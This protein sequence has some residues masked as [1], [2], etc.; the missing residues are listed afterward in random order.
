MSFYFN[1]FF[2]YSQVERLCDRLQSATRIE[3]RRDA[4]RALRALSKVNKST[5]FQ[6]LISI[7]NK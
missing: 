5:F 2:V 3:D 6:C 1:D 4:V 7:E